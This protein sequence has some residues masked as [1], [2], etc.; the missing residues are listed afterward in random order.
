MFDAISPFDNRTGAEPTRPPQAALPQTRD[1]DLQRAK[2]AGRIVFRGGESGTRLADVFQKS[3]VRVLFP[4]L[5]GPTEAVLVNTAGGIA[6]GDAFEYRVEAQAGA[7]F[8]VTTQ[9]AEKVYRALNEPARIVTHLR[10]EDGAKLAWLPQ[11]TIIFDGA[12]LHRT[13]EVDVTSGAELLALE[14]ML[15]GRAASGEMMSHGEIRDS[16]RIRRDG[17][18][19]WA[20]TFRV[21]DDMFGD[22][23]RPALLDGSTALATLLYLGPDLENRLERVR[24]LLAGLSCRSGAT[25][26]SGLLVIRFASK[27]PGELRAA[28][29]RFLQEFNAEGRDD[30]F[31]LPKMWSC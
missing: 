22:L 28:L 20:D 4:R 26:V 15:L 5:P 11:E 2:G 17:R 24:E 6:G 31:R 21:T 9:A 13:T 14:W 1:S 10:A 27:V 8:T 3:P 7:S 16:W 23:N 25:L 18:L 30:P 12:R 29:R 19:V